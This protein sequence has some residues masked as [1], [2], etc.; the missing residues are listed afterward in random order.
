MP[1]GTASNHFKY[2][3]A[4]GTIDLSTD[5]I[6]VL[7]M[8]SGYTFNKDNVAMFKN[9]RANSSSQTLTVEQDDDSITG[10]GGDFVTAGFIVGNQITTDLAGNPGP[11]T[12]LTV[13][14]TVITVSE[15]LTDE[16]PTAA[17]TV[18]SD[19]EL[20]TGFG[21]T[22]NTMTLAGVAVAEDDANDRAELTCNTVTWTAAGGA[23]GPTP[24]AILYDDTSADNTVIG[25]ID[26]GAE[27]TA[28]DGATF[29]IAN[30]KI[31]LS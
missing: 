12:I 17:K 28:N 13:S 19:D 30:I 31:R 14:A 16:G 7:L 26:F 1:T 25:Y 9:I 29:S 24:G 2:A 18:S 21:Y 15:A 3:L 10:N 23:I 5:S 20:T 8:R 11:Y 27:M 4:T 22:Q 6:K